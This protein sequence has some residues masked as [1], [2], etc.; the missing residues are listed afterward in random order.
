MKELSIHARWVYELLTRGPHHL[1]QSWTPG[2]A[3]AGH[4]FR[5]LQ[6]PC[7]LPSGNLT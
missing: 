2:R 3:E 5:L 7:F 6:T 1:I 4:R